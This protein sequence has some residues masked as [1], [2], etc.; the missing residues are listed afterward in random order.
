MCSNFF[1]LQKIIESRQLEHGVELQLNGMKSVGLLT[2]LLKELV[3]GTSLMPGSQV[4]TVN[5]QFGH[6]LKR[7]KFLDIDRTF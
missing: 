3:S 5:S 1:Q 7:L 4:V 2:L 6:I